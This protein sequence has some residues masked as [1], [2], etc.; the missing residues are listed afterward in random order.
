MT[1]TEIGRHAE[2]AAAVY[3]ATHGFAILA[4]NWRTRWCEIDLIARRDQ[5]VYFVEVKYRAR[6]NWGSGLDCVTPAKLHQMRFAAQFWQS[7]N[8][9]SGKCQLLAIAVAGPD[10]TITRAVAIS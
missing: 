5:T 4:R 2:T 10:F 9:Y 8:S 7:A 1:T 6:P 3:L